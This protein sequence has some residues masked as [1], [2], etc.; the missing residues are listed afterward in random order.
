MNYR[1]GF[2]RLGALLSLG[3]LAFWAAL[4]VYGLYWE[5]QAAHLDIGALP[6]P[7]HPVRY[8]QWAEFARAFLLF[9]VVP[10]GAYWL[11]YWLLPWI[12]AG[13]RSEK[14]PR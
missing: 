10:I 5:W 1:R 6:D 7:L 13:F 14:D 12:I 4:V 9:G 11:L 8:N 3:S 2:R